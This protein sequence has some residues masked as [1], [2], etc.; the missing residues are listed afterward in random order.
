VGGALG[1][2]A[3]AY[4]GPTIG[5]RSLFLLGLLPAL[6]ALLIRAWVPESP[7]W[8]ILRGRREEARRSIAWA[9]Q[10][11]PWE[12]A[13][14]AVLPEVEHTPWREPSKYPRSAALVCMTGLSQTSGVGLARAA[15]AGRRVLADR[16][17]DEGPLDRGDRRRADQAR[18]R[19]GARD[20]KRP[21]P[22]AVLHPIVAPQKVGAEL[23]EAW[24]ADLAHD[25]VDLAAED[26]D[27][28]LDAGW[29]AGDGAVE[30]RSAEE[31]E[32]GAET[33]GDQDVSAAAYAA[34]E[35]H[36]YFVADRRLDRR[37]SFQRGRRLVELAA[38]MV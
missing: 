14:P 28:L 23:I 1:A 11:D 20:V 36:A 10:I 30:R 3:G 15:L 17:R 8:L 7:R 38:A 12:I 34:V 4:L 25:E 33:E 27:H 18:A 31:D 9:L 29:P 35:H 5:W 13:L 19:Q 37:Q 26:V 16:N 6:L 22:S 2:A 24:T 32:L 21:D